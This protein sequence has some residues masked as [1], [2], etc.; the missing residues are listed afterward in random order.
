MLNGQKRIIDKIVS[1]LGMNRAKNYRDAYPKSLFKRFE[2]L[3][4]EDLYFTCYHRLSNSSHVMAED[5]ISWLLGVMQEDKK[6][7]FSIGRE[8]VAY[9]RMMCLIVLITAIEAIGVFSIA[10]GFLGC[11]SLIQGCRSQLIGEIERLSDDAG[12]PKDEI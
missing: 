10:H 5:T 11:V 9:S 3:G 4:K 7:L 8:A 1:D 12:V 6:L 2:T